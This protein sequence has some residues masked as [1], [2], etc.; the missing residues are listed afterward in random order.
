MMDISGP[1]IYDPPMPSLTTLSA[2]RSGDAARARPTMRDVAALAGVSLK[3]VSRVINAEP[4]VSEEVRARV[5]RAI[6][7]LDYRPNLTASNLRRSGG[8]TATIGLV[9]EDLANP[10]SAAIIRA[11]EDTARPRGVTVVAGSIDEDPDRETA[12]VDEFIARRVDGLIVVPA[13]DDQ[14][15]L[16]AERRSGLP[17]VFVDRPPRNLETDTVVAANRAGATIGVEH[18]LGQGH[19]RIAFVGDLPSI[20]TAAERYAGYED[21]LVRAGIAVDDQLIRRAVRGTDAAILAVT[22]L[23]ATPEP[24]TAVF[25]AQNVLSIGAFAALRRLGRRADVALVGFDDFP[26]ADLLDPGVTVVAQDPLAIGRLAAEILF[27]RLDGDRAPSAT[28]V[29][30][31]RL[32]ERG[33]GEIAPAR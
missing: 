19:R 30:P 15:Y 9:V 20:W 11:V 1:I 16:A 5:G 32:I 22:E 27:R 8:K 10:Y 2:T 18:L 3:T 23:L 21:A 24:P 6:L 25:A 7:Q 4:A 13:A 33:S 31:T 29:V 28:H 14:S 12:L 17:M 26:L